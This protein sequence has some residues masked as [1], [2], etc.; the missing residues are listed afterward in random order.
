MG[1]PIIQ[2][3]WAAPVR[4]SAD[5]TR[6]HFE[7]LVS[8]GHTWWDRPTWTTGEHSQRALM[9]L[10]PCLAQQRMLWKR[11]QPSRHHP[12]WLR[13]WQRLLQS[14]ISGRAAVPSLG[15]EIDSPGEP[16]VFPWSGLQPR[17]IKSSISR[18]GDTCTGIYES[19]PDGSDVRPRGE[20]LLEGDSD[21]VWAWAQLVKGSRKRS[22]RSTSCSGESGFLT[23]LKHSWQTLYL[24]GGCLGPTDMSGVPGVLFEM[25]VFGFS[26]INRHSHIYS[27]LTLWKPGIW[28]KKNQ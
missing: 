19:S 18:S 22:L 7:A 20:A 12:A 5:L 1:R 26:A 9:A 6:H 16:T 25:L 10:D 8:G 28:W 27:T 21:S 14:D 13:I 4:G 24:S 2:L 11:T 3:P 15:C 23:F 17:L